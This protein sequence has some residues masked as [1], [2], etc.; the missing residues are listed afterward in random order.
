MITPAL[1][2]RKKPPPA[3]GTFDTEIKGT[4]SADGFD[5]IRMLSQ[6]LGC[7]SGR[8]TRGDEEHAQN[9]VEDFYILVLH[10]NS[11]WLVILLTV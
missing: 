11:S 6:L 3:T 2:S 9:S 10:G 4:P 1:N 8:R 7:L 5:E